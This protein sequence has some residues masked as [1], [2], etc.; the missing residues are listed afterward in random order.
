MPPAASGAVGG[1]SLPMYRVPL[2]SRARA[3]NL[4]TTEGQY[5]L[6]VILT[7]CP[8]TRDHDGM[9]NTGLLRNVKG[10]SHVTCK[11]HEVQVHPCPI[12]SIHWSRLACSDAGVGG[13]AVDVS[14]VDGGIGVTQVRGSGRGQSQSPEVVV[15]AAQFASR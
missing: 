2:W 11:S 5:D 13:F 12:P 8:R 3:I 9:E 10:D 6:T 7:E 4:T 1:I 15:S 14:D